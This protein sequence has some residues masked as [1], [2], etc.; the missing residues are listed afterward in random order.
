M[1]LVADLPSV[2]NGKPVMPA[3]AL[4]FTHINRYVLLQHGNLDNWNENGPEGVS[5]RY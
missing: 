3:Q 2:R 4:I 5:N 1:A